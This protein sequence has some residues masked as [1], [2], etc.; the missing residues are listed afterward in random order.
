M[1][2]LKK[3]IAFI[4]LIAFVSAC[5]QNKEEIVL[6]TWKVDIDQ[7]DS[8]LIQQIESKLENTPEKMRSGVRVGLE[9]EKAETLDRYR[10]MSFEF[11]SDSTYISTIDNVEH[12]GKWYLDKEGYYI[13]VAVDEGDYRFLLKESLEGGNYTIDYKKDQEHLR[14]YK[15]E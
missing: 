7:A 1:N 9:N 15:K 4:S 8:L 13:H 5:S 11:K 6:G 2:Y 12:K 3:A 10:E 14:L